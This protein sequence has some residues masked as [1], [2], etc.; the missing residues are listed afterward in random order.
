MSHFI[1]TTTTC[2]AS[3]LA[4]LL[5]D[6]VFRLHASP[7]SIVSDRDPVLT[8]TVAREMAACLSI[9][10][11]FSTAFH[12][13][14]DGQT[15]RVNTLL[16]QYLRAYCN[17]QQDDWH[18]YLSLAEFSYNNTIS[19]STKVSPFF[20][21]YG[22]NPRYRIIT[23][24]EFRNKSVEIKKFQQYL[25][26]LEDFIRS[27]IRYAQDVAAQ[28]AN[29]SRIP[30][31]VFKVGD[32]VWLL[33]KHIST[34]R[35]S[36]KLDHKRLGPFK[37]SKKFSSQ[38]YRLKLPATMKVHP[39]FHVSLLEPSATDPLPGQ[40]SPPP[41]PIIVD[42]EFEYVV[43]EI[44]DAKHRGSKPFLVKYLGDPVPT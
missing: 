23:R 25:K 15:E 24:S 29:L 44:L 39:V 40:I 31:P 22:Y 5:W 37:I 13:R 17:Y 43:E 36:N 9:E 34:T 38:A 41:P 33:R 30:P 6:N 19:S 16:E 4:I 8:S 7:E 27:E 11:H 20:A 10:L 32:K 35:P 2:S 21:N 12:P 26:N 42:G 28:N 18:S 3:D 14:T 1:P